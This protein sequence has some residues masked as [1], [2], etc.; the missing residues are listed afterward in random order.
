MGRELKRVPLDF[1]WPLNKIWDGFKN[2]HYTAKKCVYCD[3]TGYGR[4]AKFISDQWYGYVQ[5]D[6]SMTGSVKLTPETDIIRLIAENNVTRS[7]E[8][9]GKGERAIRNE[10]QRLSDMWNK[11][12]CHHL[13]QHDVNALWAKGRLADLNQNWRENH[14]E[15]VTPPTASEVNRWSL[16][17]F[18]HDAINHSYCVEAKCERLGI[19]KTCWHCNGEGDIWASPEDEKLYEEWKETPPPTG[20]GWQL[21]ETTSEGSPIGPVLETKDQ[22]ID[23]LIKQ[24]YSEGAAEKFAEVGHAFS[25]MI[26]NGKM[27]KNIESLNASFE[28]DEE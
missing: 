15:G 25:F 18:G 3:G 9:Y 24:G 5:F 13:D 4:Q 2:P 7:P 6:P 17:G 1:D 23:W 19:I 16:T 27:Y 14:N 10:A 26:G 22:F 28:E 21:W 20:E 12:W 11:Q 8:F